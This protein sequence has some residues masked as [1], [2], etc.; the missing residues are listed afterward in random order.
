MSRE[1]VWK[2][3]WDRCEDALFAGT[4]GFRCVI[5]QQGNSHPIEI[6]APTGFRVSKA[7]EGGTQ[8]IWSSPFTADVSQNHGLMIGRRCVEMSEN[9]RGIN[10]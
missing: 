6:G 4:E 8:D 9:H 3:I 2:N 1:E 10:C 7:L 5:P